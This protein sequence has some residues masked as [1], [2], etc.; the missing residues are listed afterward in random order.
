MKKDVL[1]KLVS[2]SCDDDAANPIAYSVTPVEP[3]EACKLK[4]AARVPNCPTLAPE[5]VLGVNGKPVTSAFPTDDPFDV[6]L[7]C[8]SK[9]TSSPILM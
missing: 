3:I 2:F 1:V 8:I 9:N 5:F 6:R 4:D 7:T